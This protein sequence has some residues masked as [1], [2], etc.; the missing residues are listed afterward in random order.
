MKYKYVEIP[1][2]LSLFSLKIP[3]MTPGTAGP[4][5]PLALGASLHRE[6]GKEMTGLNSLTIY[7]VH[8]SQNAWP[9]TI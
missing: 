3:F 6:A 2:S 7:I 4:D 8:V 1:L 5:T 9:Y